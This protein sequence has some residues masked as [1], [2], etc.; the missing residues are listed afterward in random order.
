MDELRRLFPEP[1]LSPYFAA[2]VTANLPQPATRP[3]PRWLRLYWVALIILTVAALAT[4]H[5]PRWVLYVA[6]PVS[7]VMVFISRRGFA[8]WVAPFLR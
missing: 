5:P 1:R 3:A 6:V 4:A 2:R 7:F 8:G